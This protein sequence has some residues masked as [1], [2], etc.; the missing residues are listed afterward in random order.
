MAI[1]ASLIAALA[2]AVVIPVAWFPK[3][4]AAPTPGANAAPGA[5][6]IELGRGIALAQCARCHIYYEPSA[7]TAAQWRQLLPRMLDKSAI[8]GDSAR[9]V[10]AYFAAGAK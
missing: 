1:G 9:K 4:P 7:R 5:S 6:D 2:L 3:A 8:S 10:E